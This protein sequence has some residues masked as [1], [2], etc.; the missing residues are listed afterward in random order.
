[1]VDVKLT[2]EEKT[3]KNTGTP[4]DLMALIGSRG[5]TIVGA[6]T[7]LLSIA[8]N[9]VTFEFSKIPIG[10]GYL[11]VVAFAVCAYITLDGFATISLK[12]VSTLFLH[13]VVVCIFAT[14]PLFS[15]WDSARQRAPQS[16]SSENRTAP[17][18]P[19]APSQPSTQ[20]NLPPFSLEIK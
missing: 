1:M 17:P 18:R 5:F 8:A 19:G 9:V 7:F 10:Y 4:A 20:L 16:I 3:E 6:V 2:A 15:V 11:A 14:P 12:S 13:I